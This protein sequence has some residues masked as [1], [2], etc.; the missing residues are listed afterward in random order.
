MSRFR[1][2]QLAV[3]LNVAIV[4]VQIVFGL[5]AH[6][7]GLLADAGHNLADVGALVISMIAVRMATRAP[8]GRHSFGFHRATIL[9]AQTNAASILLVTGVLA[10]EAVRRFAHPATVDG[11]LV[12]VVAAFGLVGNLIAAAV[13]HDGSH[14]LNMR[15]A[16]LHLLGDAAASAGVLVSGVVIALTSGWDRL[17]P[18]VSLVI[19]VFI[20][21]RAIA[22]LREASAVL[23]EAA[24][25]GVDLQEVASALA[26]VDG[27]ESVHD[28]HAWSLSS[29]IAALSAHLV[30]DGHPT[31]EEAQ[32]IG[33]RAKHLISQRWAIA[34]ATLEM[35]CENCTPDPADACAMSDL[36]P[37][38]A[39]HHHAH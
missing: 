11:G 16:L 27:V 37:V 15:G 29:D 19:A 35:E 1:R 3:A 30:L 21:W 10:L 13:L 5:A 23:L 33:A 9:A 14:D 4:G 34:H 20:A 28:L 24:P 26:D 32:A 38:E 18:A 12:A 2:L 39:H 22:L 31:L 8:K 25:I 36:H 6:S 17:D 7:I